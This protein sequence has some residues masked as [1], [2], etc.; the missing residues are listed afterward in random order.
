MTSVATPIDRLFGALRGLLTGWFGFSRDVPRLFYATSG[1]SLML[2][3][4]VVERVVLEQ[5]AGTTMSPWLFVS[6][7]LT[8]REELVRGAPDWLPWA[9]FLWT[10]PFLWIAVTMTLRRAYSA[11]YSAWFGLL[12]LVPG[13]NLVTMVIM[14]LLPDRRSIPPGDATSPIRHTVSHYRAAL[15][16]LVAGLLLALAML[17]ISVYAFGTY[18]SSLFL[19]T[20]ILMGAVASVITNTAASTRL[21][22]SVCLGMLTVILGG[23]VL[24]AFALEGIICLAM[25]A[26]LALPLGALGGAL[27]KTIADTSRRPLRGTSTILF[28]L[29]GIAGLEHLTHAQPEWMVQTEIHVAADID[30]VWNCVIHFPDLPPPTAWYYRWGIACPIRAEISGRGVGAVRRCIFTTGVFVE[31][32]TT[33]NA[34]HRLAFDVTQQPAPMFELSPYHNIHP[35]HLEGALRSTRGEFTL[36]PSPDGG[37]LLTGRTWYQFDMFPHAYWTLWSDLFI[38]RIHHRVLEHV[39]HHAE[40][41]GFGTTT[42]PSLQP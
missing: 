21:S 31:P 24:W 11:G 39:K 4:Y 33:W 22:S 40:T 12:I 2:V 16:G 38:H 26:P 32:I 36:Q 15:I 13:V 27:G 14:A 5:A 7:V 37:T 18:G 35:P 8:A 10:L 25:A 23:G 28:L 19:G 34:P 3:K 17:V 41:D 1:L 30:Q 9:W 20:P 42:K 6:P 29:P